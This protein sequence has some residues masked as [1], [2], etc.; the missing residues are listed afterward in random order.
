MGLW[1]DPINQVWISSF[2]RIRKEFEVISAGHSVAAERQLWDYSQLL[3]EVN[4]ADVCSW[5]GLFSG[6]WTE[7]RVL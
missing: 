2:G 4:N 3:I 5:A 7:I 6:S 1:F